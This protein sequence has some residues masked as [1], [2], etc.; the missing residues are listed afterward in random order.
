MGRVTATRGALQYLNSVGV[1]GGGGRPSGRAPAHP[2]PTAIATTSPQSTAKKLFQA[3]LAFI[4]IAVLLALLAGVAAGQDSPDIEAAHVDSAVATDVTGIAQADTADAD[5]AIAVAV[6]PVHTDSTTSITPVDG[7]AAATTPSVSSPTVTNSPP[8]NFWAMAVLVYFGLAAIPLILSA[9]VIGFADAAWVKRRRRHRDAAEE[10]NHAPSPGVLRNDP[11]PVG[12][13]PATS[14]AVWG[15]GCAS[16]VGPVRAENQDRALAWDQGSTR[17]IIVADGMGG[18]P[19]GG[20][21]AESASASLARHLSSGIISGRFAENPLEVI[22]AGFYA[23]AGCLKLKNGLSP[24]GRD[25]L[26][27]TLITTVITPYAYYYGFIGDGGLLVRRADGTVEEVVTGHKDPD[28]PNVLHASLG[29][30]IHG[31]PEIG[32]MPRRPGDFILVGTDGVFDRIP[33]TTVFAT[34]VIDAARDN[35]NGNLQSV[36]D[37]IIRQFHE[38]LDDDG[39]AICDDNMSLVITAPDNCAPEDRTGTALPEE[40]THAYA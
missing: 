1:G 27:T 10:K 9:F 26:R 21:A 3:L 18:L 5:A 20:D 40:M 24:S 6:P 22:R 15:V 11:A 29:P 13:R 32:I 30:D 39:A 2:A 14:P 16:V 17:C 37:E 33:D 12:A 31:A 23:A 36:V 8:F 19:R 35:Y 28:A 4:G 7:P 38:A 25:G 34:T